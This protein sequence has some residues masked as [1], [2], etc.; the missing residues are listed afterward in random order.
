MLK[1]KTIQT[2]FS[3]V[4]VLIIILAILSG[5]LMRQ[6]LEERREKQQ[7]A[8]EIPILNIGSSAINKGGQ[9]VDETANWQTYRNEGWGFEVKYPEMLFQ[10][11][12]NEA[13]LSHT[14]K[15]F[16]TYSERDGSDLGLAQDIVVEFLQDSTKCDE[17]DDDES[18]YS[19]RNIAVDFSI[20]EIM[21]RQYETGAEGAGVIYYCVQNE[22]EENIFLIKRWFLREA[23]S[24]DLKKQDD[25][26]S[27]ERQKEIFD[28]ILSTFKFID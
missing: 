16:H 3:K 9:E 13:K 14:L 28:Q 11:S 8:S 26:I 24:L 1:N 2:G 6:S 25:F 4:V 18:S 27:N 15:D 22:Y 7:I 21:G 19:L 10:L 5:V 20:D 17:I 12:V 23:Y